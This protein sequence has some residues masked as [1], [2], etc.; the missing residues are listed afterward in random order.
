[1]GIMPG[2]IGLTIAFMLIAT[3]VLWCVIK[4]NVHIL[5]KILVISVVTWYSLVLFYTPNKLLGW[6]TTTDFPDGARVIHFLIQE[7]T[8]VKVGGFYFWLID[9]TQERIP[10]RIVDIINPKNIFS[11][12]EKDTPRVY[13]MSYDREFHKMLMKKNKEK[14]KKKGIMRLYHEMRK[15]GQ[16]KKKK[17][18]QGTNVNR[19]KF[20]IKIQNPA[21]MLQKS[22]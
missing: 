17:M 14:K 12:T 11:Y 18:R 22:M 1:M 16:N 13:Y 7:P 3:L 9:D 5:V 2:Y 8:Q 4:S 19:K 10:M 6:P 15:G 21:D 20:R